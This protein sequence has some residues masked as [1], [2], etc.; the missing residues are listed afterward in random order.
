M[1][2]EDEDLEKVRLLGSGVLPLLLPTSVPFPQN[3]NTSNTA[4][5]FSGWCELS[6]LV[7]RNGV[8]ILSLCLGGEEKRPRL[9]VLSSYPVQFHHV[10]TMRARAAWSLLGP[11]LLSAREAVPASPRWG[12][13][14]GFVR[15]APSTD[16]SC[17]FLHRGDDL[18]V[19]WMN[20]GTHP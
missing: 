9:G 8:A 1:E 19:W 6:P 14:E 11:R 10:L 16:T 5:P 13:Q 18:N 20:Y 15:A 2:D 4:D 17:P 12:L 7:G 3:G